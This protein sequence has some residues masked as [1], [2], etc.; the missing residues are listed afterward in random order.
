M[1]KAL[2][3]VIALLGYACSST[4]TYHNLPSINTGQLNINNAVFKLGV[5][6]IELPSYLTGS[7]I[8]MQTPHNEIKHLPNVR[9]AENLRETLNSRLLL[10]LQKKFN[11]ANI[12]QHPWDIIGTL[13]LKL[14][15]NI[16]RFILF[17][18]QIHLSADYALHNFKKN[19]RSQHKFNNQ[20]PSSHQLQN[21]MQTMGVVFDSLMQDIGKKT[22]EFASQ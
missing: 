22:S 9:W 17:N 16:T 13:D 19:T 18:H 4:H 1:K 10:F 7:T 15:V 20:Q 2:V 8:A 6:G 3:I 21:V 11:Q 5:S 12:Y 14:D